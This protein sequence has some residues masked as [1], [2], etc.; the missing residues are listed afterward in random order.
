MKIYLSVIILLM[1]PWL[2]SCSGKKSAADN[3]TTSEN[4]EKN[5]IS[6]V[7]LNAEQQKLA[8]ILVDTVII[9]SLQEKI[10]IPARVVVDERRVAHLTAR[11]AGRVEHVCAFLGDRVEKNALLA[12][13]YSPDFLAA[14]AEFIQAEDRSRLAST[15]LDSSESLMARS[16]FESTRRKLLVMGA[17]DQMLAELSSTRIPQTFIEIRAPFAGAI[18]ETYDILGHFVEMGATLFHLIDISRV[19]VLADIYENELAKIRPGLTAEVTVPA[20]PGEK[21][22]GCL[23]TI[24]DMLDEASRTVKA[25]IE[26]ENPA[27]KLKPQMFGQVRLLAERNINGIVVSAEAVVQ[28]NSKALVFVALDDTTFARREVALGAAVDSFIEIRDGLKPG[29]KVVTKGIFEL[30]SELL[31]ELF[32]EEE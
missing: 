30:K 6:F 19:W 28:E 14:Q 16:I 29:E 23:T 7:H 13:I 31:K 21:F 9:G 22:A 4:A 10:T 2:V 8:G 18:S 15:R 1:I 12:T 5:S 24:F 20:Y 17:T 3:L 11:V 32:A 26:V 25:R 27:G